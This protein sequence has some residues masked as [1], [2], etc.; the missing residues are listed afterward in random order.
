MENQTQGIIA[1]LKHRDRIHTSSLYYRI[2]DLL[3]QGAD[4]YEL[5]ED[6]IELHDNFQK[7]MVEKLSK[8]DRPYQI[9]ISTEQFENLKQNILIE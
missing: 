9:V 2:I 6:V 4:V 3:I 5:L 8:M 1:R 7:E